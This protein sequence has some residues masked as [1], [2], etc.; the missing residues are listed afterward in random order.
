MAE[1]EL[2]SEDESY[3]VPEWLEK[4]VTGEEKY[5]NSN[6]TINPYKNWGQL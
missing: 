3:K 1:T 4:E 5:Y 6:L 2:N